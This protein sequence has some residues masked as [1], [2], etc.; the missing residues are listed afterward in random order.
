MGKGKGIDGSHD[1]EKGAA[2]R[3][4]LDHALVN[5]PRPWPRESFR[6]WLGLECFP[7]PCFVSFGGPA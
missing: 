1:K 7:L 3:L 2:R 5:Q 4:P 6:P